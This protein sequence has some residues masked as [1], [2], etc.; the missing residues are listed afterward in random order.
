MMMTTT[1]MM[2]MMMW[3]WMCQ[4]PLDWEAVFDDA[5]GRVVFRNDL[6]QRTQFNCPARPFVRLEEGEIAS[7]SSQVDHIYSHQRSIQW[8]IPK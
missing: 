7:S 5:T 8:C 1:T 4:V 6:T 2:M 3:M